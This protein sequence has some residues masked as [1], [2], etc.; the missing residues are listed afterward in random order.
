MFLQLMEGGE[1]AKVLQ[2]VKR[3]KLE[4][5]E[6]FCKYTLF[7]VANGVSD[8]HRKDVLHR[9]VKSDNILFKKDGTIKIADLGFSI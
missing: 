2:M 4:L 8:M 9:D 1:L 6:Q 7:C 3:L 5:S